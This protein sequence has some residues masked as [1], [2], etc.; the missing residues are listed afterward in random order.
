MSI[1]YDTVHGKIPA[2]TPLNNG[3]FPISA[4]QKEFFHQPYFTQIHLVIHPPV[5]RWHQLFHDLP[6]VRCHDSLAF[7]HR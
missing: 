3:I 6:R 5:I 1:G 7:C 4:G 2:N